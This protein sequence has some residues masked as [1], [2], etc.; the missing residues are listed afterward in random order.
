[1]KGAAPGT[2][3]RMAILPIIRMGHPLLRQVARPVPTPIPPAVR[4]LAM[5]MI[6]TMEDAGGA[7]LAAPQVAADWRLIVFRAPPPDECDTGDRAAARTIQA[8]INPELVPLG[9]ATADTETQ[10]GWEGCLSVPDLRG[11]VR[12]HTRIRYQG[13]DLD[14]S[15]VRRDAQGFHARV[16]QHEIDHLDGVLYLDRMDDLRYLSY[17]RELTR[18][19]NDPLFRLPS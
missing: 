18:F 14:G 5:D 8:L 6:D 12:R 16:V 7:G 4:Q 15:P 9:T 17:T 11:A 13:L 19:A 1:M 2:T 10:T 3:T